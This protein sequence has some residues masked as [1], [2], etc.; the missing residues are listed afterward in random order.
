M[1]TLSHFMVGDWIVHTY[2]GVGQIKAIESKPIQGKPA[3]CFKVKTKDS[4]FWFPVKNSDNPR[5]RPIATKE[6]V[7]QA[8][9][10][11]RRKP[12]DLDK[13]KNYWKEQIREV[14]TD[15]DLVRISK[16][17]RNLSGQ[18]THR[19]LIQSE[20][21]AL[22][23]FKEKLLQEWAVIMDTDIDTIRPRLRAYIQESKT[24]IGILR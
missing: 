13:D 1:E 24:K 7:K 8:I 15:G 2:Y 12:A 3:T 20:V 14:Q 11:L 19:N 23:N 16:L 9:N 10:Y 21:T 5:I 4:T 22:E 6:I 18:K 17:I